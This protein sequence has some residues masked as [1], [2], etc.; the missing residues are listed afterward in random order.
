MVR[1]GLREATGLPEVVRDRGRVL[2]QRRC[3]DT[4]ER[5]SHSRVRAVAGAWG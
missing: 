1:S 2:G 5:V 4:L 3:V